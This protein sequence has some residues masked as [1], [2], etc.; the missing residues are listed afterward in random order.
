MKQDRPEA[1]PLRIGIIANSV[2]A[3]TMDRAG[4]FVHL[5]ETA[6]RW[7]G[8]RVTVLGPANTEP[9]F[10]KYLK[11]EAF[12]AIP[13]FGSGLSAL[14]MM[15]RS[16]ASTLKVRRLRR[17]CDVVLA[18]SHSVPD[19][20]PAVLFGGRHA[21]V[22]LW[23]FIG[24]PFER[25]GNP[26]RNLLAYGNERVGRLLAWRCRGFILGSKTLEREIGAEHRAFT[27]ITTNGVDEGLPAVSQARSGSVFVGRLH[28]AKGLDDLL[29]GW[30]KV[31]LSL[32]GERLT[33]VGKGTP[34]YRAR[35]ERSID[36]RNMRNVIAI[37]DDVGNHEK[38]SI[39]AAAKLFVFPS[40]EEGWGIALA[41]AMALGLPCVTY[42]LPP[43]ADIFPRGRLD[44]AVGDP[45]T[46]AANVVLLLEDS[47]RWNALSAQALEQATD[48]KWSRA[49]ETELGA[50]RDIAR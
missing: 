32:P 7:Q 30:S 44:A 48:F 5:V 14:S 12:I 35:L 33:I 6:R 23:H 47:E 2:D 43:F 17:E 22:Q 9:L 45:T 24:N 15:L 41:E 34:S 16:V 18:L 11:L 10:R 29:E 27:Y 13:S 19:V 1:R 8:V 26:M 4:G 50:L 21:A 28:P 36:E 40:R 49:A 37:R 38:L 42:Q 46:F 39:L 20:L 25:G 3:L 31:Q